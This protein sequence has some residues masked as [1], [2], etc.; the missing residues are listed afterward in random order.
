MK[1]TNIV[2][3]LIGIFSF[4]FAKP[5]N[6][7]QLFSLVN[8]HFPDKN[9]RSTE[10]INDNL[11]LTHFEKGGF[12]LSSRDDAF[13]GILAYSDKAGTQGKH[14]A[15]KAQCDLYDKE[16]NKYLNAINSQ[17]PDWVSDK[18]H[19]LDKIA[20]NI[21]GPLLTSIWNQ[22]PHY[23][24]QFPN[25][26]MPEYNE[27]QALV[28]CVAVVMGQLMNYYEHP[29]RGYGK[30]W[31][32]S[33]ST[34]TNMYADFDTSSYDYENMP[35]SL[36]DRF[37]NLTVPEDQKKDLASFLLQCA[38]SVEM[39][40]LPEASSAA[41]EDMMYALRSHFDYAPSMYIKNKKDYSEQDWSILLQQEIDAGRPLPYRGQGSGGGH[42]FIIDGYKITEN[43]HYHINWGWGGSY[44][45]WY[46]LSALEA[47]SG[48]NFNDHQ[49]AVFNIRANDDNVTRYLHTS[50]EGAESG[51][52]YD[53]GGFFKNQG[54]YNLVHSGDMSYGFD[55]LD[56][57]LVS[58]KFQVPNDRNAKLSLWA[59]M[60]NLNRHCSVY[61]STSDTN[62]SSFTHLL[63]NITPASSDWKQ[64]DYSLRSYR[65]QN[66][67]LGIR[68]N[69]SD[70]YIT[71]DDIEVT[72]PRS[73]SAITEKM[74]DSFN[75]L[76]A[77]P[78]PFNPQTNINYKVETSASVSLNIYDVKGKLI[79]Q[80]FQEYQSPG[81]YK[82]I[83]N[84][85]SLPSGIYICSLNMD[86][87]LVSSRKLLLLK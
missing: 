79:D 7:E 34:N 33:E 68:Y 32:Y 20:I 39:E 66:V 53:G 8:H 18:Q 41:Y 56:Q 31:Y 57:W 59:Y 76:K 81:D 6:N 36:C 55:S 72:K 86:G 29:P 70:G 52:I 83:W 15:F 2:L 37:G 45:G 84:A 73:I 85:E 10:L 27:Q 50:F 12:V 47:T 46:R 49:G 13:P 38:T 22:R 51:W 87:K 77:Y 40:F 42:A 28:G 44:D 61:L 3:S 64:Y 14:P 16:I 82:H 48:Y 75:I 54:T 78:N 60:L 71:V 5:I 69:M 23:N 4:L 25:F 11:I 80:L 62:R 63:G 9:I 67:Y 21:K 24:S 58:P 26:V 35:D 19:S 1:K 17:H 43:T 74:P 30:R 65:D